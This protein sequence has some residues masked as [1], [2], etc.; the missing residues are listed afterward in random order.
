[1]WTLLPVR[2]R[3]EPCDHQG[4][5]HAFDLQ[6][7]RQLLTTAALRLQHGINNNAFKV[8]ASC[9]ERLG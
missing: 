5:P 9:C 3:P 6:T 2:M 8:T 1:M 4:I 7:D